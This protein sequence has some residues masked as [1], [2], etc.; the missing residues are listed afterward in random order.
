MI[1]IVLTEAQKKAA[2]E[3]VQLSGFYKMRLASFLRLDI[4]TLN[5]ILKDDESFSQDIKAAESAFIGKIVDKTVEKRP[6]FILK[7]K[8]AEEFPDRLQVEHSGKLSFTEFIQEEKLD[9]SNND[10]QQPEE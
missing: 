3:Y 4:K 10:D 2:I 5:R 6:D 7:S 9:E 8:Y 1:D